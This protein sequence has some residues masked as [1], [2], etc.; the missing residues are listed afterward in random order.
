MIRSFGSGFNLVIGVLL[1]EESAEIGF[2]QHLLRLELNR[3]SQYVRVA[4]RSE[5]F[6]YGRFELGFGE[7][8][9]FVST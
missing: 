2:D 6:D 9:F 1:D 4:L 3:L 7:F 5:E 8:H